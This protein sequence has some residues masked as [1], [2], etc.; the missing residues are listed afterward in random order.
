[1][2]CR[3][4]QKLLSASFDG[5]LDRRRDRAVNEHVIACPRCQRFAS[6]LPEYER[7]LNLLTAPQRLPGFTDRLLARLPE[8]PTWRTQVR[9]WLVSLRPLPAAAA[10]VA[11]ACGAAMAL[12]LSGERGAPIADHSEPAD[13]L[14]AESFEALPGQSAAARYLALLQEAEG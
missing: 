14:Y 1:M 5:E 10:V 8:A 7:D 3:N 11:F 6:D 12:S 13:A 9:D 2:R 4:A